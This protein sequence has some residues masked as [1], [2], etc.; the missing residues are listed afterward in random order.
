MLLCVLDYSMLWQ[1][2]E[3]AFIILYNQPHMAIILELAT[4]PRDKRVELEFRGGGG[5]DSKYKGRTK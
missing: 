1:Q 2:D 3:Q 5:M 4:F